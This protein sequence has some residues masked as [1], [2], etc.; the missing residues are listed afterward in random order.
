MR[1]R[2]RL[3]ALTVAAMF[4]GTICG[5]SDSEDTH[6]EGEEEGK[7]TEAVCP[8]TAAPTYESFGTKFMDDYCTRCHSST[9]SGAARNG[10]PEGHD[11]DTLDG[12]LLVAEHI[13][14][15]AAA[16]PAAVNTIMP[17]SDP[18]PS[19]SERSQLGEWLACELQ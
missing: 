14:E 7:A 4:L 5:C 19:E 1:I 18:K 12:V 6:G 3:G 10:A 17:P 8:T 15:Y 13:D 2:N 9:L 11:F 16:G